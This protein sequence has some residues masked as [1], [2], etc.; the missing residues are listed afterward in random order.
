M[1]TPVPLD[2]QLIEAWEAWEAQPGSA[3]ATRRRLAAIAALGL[4]SSRTH[5]LIGRQRHHGYDVPS[6]V[7]TAIN[8]QTELRRAS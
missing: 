5:D 8:E 6:A 3:V 4:H 2:D 7:Q 1:T